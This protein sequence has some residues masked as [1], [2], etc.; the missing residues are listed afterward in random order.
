M[1][2]WK[3]FYSGVLSAAKFVRVCLGYLLG[4]EDVWFSYV[5]L[6]L[7]LGMIYMASYV[8]SSFMD[9]DPGAHDSRRRRK[10]EARTGGGGAGG[11][12]SRSTKSESS[13]SWDKKRK[14]Q[15]KQR[16]ERSRR[17]SVSLAYRHP[18]LDSSPVQLLH[19]RLYERCVLEARG[20][21]VRVLVLVVP[22]GLFGDAVTPRQGWWAYPSAVDIRKRRRATSSRARNASPQHAMLASQYQRLTEPLLRQVIHDGFFLFH[23]C[24]FLSSCFF[25]KSL[26]LLV[27]FRSFFLSYFLAFLFSFFLAFF[28]SRFLSFLAFFLAFFLALFLALF[29]AFSLSLSL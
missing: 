11:G 3:L 29:L 24:C 8:I 7:T 23:I 6:F 20:L 28:L 9:A 14:Q 18:L 17:D 21:G 25:L 22:H 4:G 5:T 12:S 19:P 15:Q 10:N 1:R 13:T 2:G 27:V 26:C 16:Q